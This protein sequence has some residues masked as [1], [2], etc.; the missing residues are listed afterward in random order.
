MVQK[1]ELGLNSLCSYI[2]GEL[3]LVCTKTSLY[4]ES[5]SWR[6]TPQAARVLTGG[7]RSERGPWE[8]LLMT[9]ATT[10]TPHKKQGQ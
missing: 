8:G 9:T 3:P 2:K 6:R 7:A 10:S 1:L 4:Q 5:K